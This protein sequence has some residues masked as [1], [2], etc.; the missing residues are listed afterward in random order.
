MAN[1]SA[2]N[3]SFNAAAYAE[4]NLQQNLPQNTT[5]ETT[6]QINFEASTVTLQ[7]GVATRR[8]IETNASET[9]IASANDNAEIDRVIN[10]ISGR[11]VGSAL[12]ELTNAL[13]N[14]PASY[15]ANVINRL[16][17]HDPEAAA[18]ILGA[19]GN[20]NNRTIAGALSHA[21]NSH[22]QDGDNFLYNIIKNGIGT[23]MISAGSRAYG[24]GNLVSLSGNQ[25]M[26]R[27]FAEKSLIYGHQL[28][29][30]GT[31]QGQ[32]IA[33]ALTNGALQ[34]ASGNGTVL[35]GVLGR[36]NAG[37]I[38]DAIQSGN[39]A[40]ARAL[41]TAARGGFGTNFF[42]S[43][44]EKSNQ[45]NSTVK[46]SMV[47]YFNRMGGQVL[48]RLTAGQTG[49][50]NGEKLSKFFENVVLPNND[51]T[52]SVLGE[53][54]GFGKALHS[55][56]SRYDED[57]RTAASGAGRLL[58]SLYTALDGFRGS[59]EQIDNIGNYLGDTIGG[60]IPFL[61]DLGP[62]GAMIGENIAR[63]LR[64]NQPETAQELIKS[65]DQAF[66]GGIDAVAEGLKNN[67]RL[68]EATRLLDTF[69]TPA[70]TALNDFIRQAN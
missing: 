36:L 47:N 64:G 57:P 16:V 12:S 50:S 65:I 2:A 9:L 7:D 67:G 4:V 26:M 38:N 53:G 13:Q 63:T 29:D 68:N 14:K 42:L 28:R 43:I 31:P 21:Y 66:F 39:P 32:Q 37:D 54:G 49:I 33:S 25:G 70:S 30:G 59:R 69:K 46:D 10:N 51:Y 11:E 3:V 27:D 61:V 58:G 34:A 62:T 1:V 8:G 55:A 5:I 24:F 17:Q 56:L 44:A 41:D 19:A 35:N 20:A 15:Q 52:R 23:N 60:T 6:Q 45:L 22:G 40:I 18:R 48:N